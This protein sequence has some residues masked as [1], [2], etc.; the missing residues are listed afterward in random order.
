MKSVNLLLYIMYHVRVPS[1]IKVANKLQARRER[2]N[3][4]KMVIT[5]REITQT[6]LR[7]VKKKREKGNEK[8][9]RKSI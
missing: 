1:D 2:E 4:K 7:R 9:E 8:L 5:E 6:N 3:V